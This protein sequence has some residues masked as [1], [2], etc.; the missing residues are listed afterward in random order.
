MM[1]TTLFSGLLVTSASAW[2]GIGGE[3]SF[4]TGNISN[5]D[6][7]FALVSPTERLRSGGVRAGVRLTE[8][9][10]VLAGYHH[11]NIE[12]TVRFY[13]DDGGYEGTYDYEDYYDEDVNTGAHATSFDTRLSTHIIS[14]GPKLDVNIKGVFYPYI[15][16]QALVT[17]QNMALGDDLNGSNSATEVLASGSTVGAAGMLGA[18]FRTPPGILPF[19]SQVALYFELGHTV[20]SVATFEPIG[21]MQNSGY[22]VRS[23]V[24]LRF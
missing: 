9:L 6:E 7:T 13:G 12:S 8:R 17:V 15:S 5:S 18:E 2:A 4:E 20:T 10:T 16:A 19:G 3:A 23:G 14:V 21:D 22:T 11:S 1:R 24:G